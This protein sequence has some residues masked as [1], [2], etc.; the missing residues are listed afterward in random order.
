MPA[1]DM[2]RRVSI[3]FLEGSSIS[4]KTAKSFSPKDL[5]FQ[6][7]QEITFQQELQVGGQAQYDTCS[8]KHSVHLFLAP[9]YHGEVAGLDTMLYSLMFNPLKFIKTYLISIR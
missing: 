9:E 2:Y 6:C 8:N 4:N 1:Y 5:V 3:H 7:V